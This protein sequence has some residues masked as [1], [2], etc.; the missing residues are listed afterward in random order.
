MSQ[1]KISA[2]IYILVA[3]FLVAL[4]V[5]TAISV[6]D[7]TSTRTDL[8]ATELI[9][10][11]D[12]AQSQANAAY[13][14]FQA[15]TLSEDAAKAKA[16]QAI[17]NTRYRGNEYLFVL[18]QTG[19]MV[20]HPIKPEMNGVDQTK[21]ADANGKPIFAD[22]VALSKTSGSGLIEYV[23]PK[24]G[25]ENP[26][27]KMSYITTFAPWGWII[28][29]GVYMNDLQAENFQSMLQH[30]GTAGL[31][32]LITIL[33]ATVI[34]RTIT[35]PISR[36]TGTMASVAAGDFSKDVEGTGRKDEIG[37]MA[38]AV[39]VFRD[40]GMKVAEMTEADAAR[41]VRDQASRA[42]MMVE[43]QG[44]FGVVVEAA[45][46]GDF[47]KRVEAEF[48]DVELNNLARSI[49]TL[50]ET[51]DRGL[52]ATG[53]VLSA[54]ADTDLTHR[55]TGD[56]H[57]A[58]AKLKSDTNAVADKLTDIVGQL[59][60]TSRT[61][62]TATGEILSGANDLS[63]RTTKQA[64]TIEETSATMDQLAATVMDNAKKA[65]NA[66]VKADAVSKSAESGGQVMAQATQAMERITTSSSKIS[67]IIGMIDDI[68]FQT[69]LLA[70]NASVE[71]ARAGEAGKGFAVVAVEVRRLAQSAAQASSEVKILIEQ[72]AVEVSGGSKLVADAA[73]KLS[74]MLEAIRE[75]NQL[76]DGIARASK[77][78]ASSIEEVNTAVRNMDEM[79]QH[80]AALVEEINAAIEQTEAQATELDRIVDI[81]A[82]DDAAE[83]PRAPVAAPKP[84]GIKGLQQRVKTA[85]KSYLSNG[86]AA[87]KQDWSEF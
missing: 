3:L 21:A 41:I 19:T 61:L 26:V 34:S 5:A 66:S 67:N 65:E 60:G 35:K 44:A 33:V 76:L 17:G 72:S 4:G 54:L 32:A 49:N 8:R 85:A 63:E 69:N 25:S 15:G 42:Q 30:L 46:G 13:A 80:N 55:I 7:A 78:Q 9:S 50:V 74:S 37:A 45:I 1:L 38:R 59:R 79:T 82:M 20:M 71:A 23:W 64:A 47:S 86:N 12:T 81:F 43:L 39:E 51:T 62:K 11:T 2:R 58:F 14:E 10:I 40:N 48:P 16:L 84:T 36:L 27:D 31:I 52:T 77:E 57:G 29:T 75:N 68:A 53:E 87:V 70:L 56:F 83:A 22:M 6:Q 18:D 73:G 24:A 28:G